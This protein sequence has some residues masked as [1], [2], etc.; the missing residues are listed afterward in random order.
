M[1]SGTACKHA[2]K[3]EKLA[4]D[5]RHRL[6]RMAEKLCIEKNVGTGEDSENTEA[7]A[8]YV[9]KLPVEET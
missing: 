3:Q 7:R 8:I 1:I 5:L 6:H 4:P 9:E 2:I